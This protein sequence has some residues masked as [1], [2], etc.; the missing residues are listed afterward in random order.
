M[1]RFKYK[2]VKK[3]TPG[4]VTLAGEKQVYRKYDDSGLYKEDIIGT[5]EENINQ[6]GPLL[7]KVMENGK[8][9]NPL[10]TLENIRSRFLKNFSCLPEDYKSLSSKKNYP[11]S[12]SP[13]LKSLQ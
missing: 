2:D 4:K 9:L 3:L 5:R 6:A 11:V 8:I 1:V 12:L 7:Q 10:P 13:G